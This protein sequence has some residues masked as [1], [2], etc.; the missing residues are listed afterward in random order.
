LII[1]TPHIIRSDDDFDKIRMAESERMSWC[2]SDVMSLY[3][4]VG[5]SA[6]PGN[7]CTCVSD[8]PTIYPDANPTGIETVPAPLPA[9]DGPFQPVVPAPLPGGG[10]RPNELEPSAP[11]ADVV[12]PAEPISNTGFQTGRPEAGYAGAMLR[13]DGAGQLPPGPPA[14]YAP[15]PPAAYSDPYTPARRLPQGP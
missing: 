7:W 1:L 8:L 4:D 10:R 14:P 15:G 3:G 12:Q 9:Y 11:P 13:Y 5:L 6:R 2:L